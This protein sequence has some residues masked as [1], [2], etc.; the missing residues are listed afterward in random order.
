[1]WWPVDANDFAQKVKNLGKERARN[2]KK[3]QEAPGQ[4]IAIA[5]GVQ[6]GLPRESFCE[7]ELFVRKKLGVR[8]LRMRSSL[9][10][11]FFS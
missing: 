3:A 2:A 5:S 7:G 4:R 1:M 8:E 11:F 10:I 9:V 6:G